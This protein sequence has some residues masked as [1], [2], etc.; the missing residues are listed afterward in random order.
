[1]NETLIKSL[2]YKA[3]ESNASVSSVARH[4]LSSWEQDLFG[5]IDFDNLKSLPVRSAIYFIID[6]DTV[7]YIGKTR[8]LNRRFQMHDR[9]TDFQALAN[10]AIFWV[11]VNESFLHDAEKLCM[12]TLTPDG[13]KRPVTEYK[14]EETVTEPLEYISIKIWRTTLPKLRQLSAILDER[15]SPVLDR[16]VSEALQKAKENTT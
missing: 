15:M 8:N 7:F 13:N 2:K 10:P 6:G 16:L 1:M 14:G 11:S 12:D 5:F 3:L 9:M 4:F